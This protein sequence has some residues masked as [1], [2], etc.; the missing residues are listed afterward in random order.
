VTAAGVVP[1]AEHLRTLPD[2]TII[3]WL[4]IPGDPTSEAV[5]FVRREVAWDTAPPHSSRPPK[6]IV[7]ISP[8]GWDPKTIEQ[9][10]V[11]FP[12]Q[13]V[14]WGEFMPDAVPV[15][16]LPLVAEC[17]HGGTWAREKA[18]EC[19][20]TYSTNCHGFT[21]RDVLTVAQRFQEWL[22]RELLPEPPE[23]RPSISS[24][25]LD[26]A[27]AIEEARDLIGRTDN[28]KLDISLDGIRTAARHLESQGQ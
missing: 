21:E 5:A 9:A 22:E 26:A 7:W 3:T 19:A 28:P 25:L 16:D 6:P 1:D 2:G 14:R 27:D 18:L 4:R 12:A 13:I 8:G 24:R 17:L 15:S 10:G 23:P 20:A 11:T